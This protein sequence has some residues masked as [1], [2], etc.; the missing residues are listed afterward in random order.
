VVTEER[1]GRQKD[2]HERR[3]AR[4]GAPTTDSGGN[5]VEKGEKKERAARK[6]GSSA[7]R[8]SKR[9]AGRSI[10][11]DGAAWAVGCLEQQIN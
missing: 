6:V 9:D 11:I 4:L 7:T 2:N 1:R 10:R 8:P 5:H 3:Q